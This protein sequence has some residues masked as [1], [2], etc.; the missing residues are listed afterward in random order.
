MSYKI[1]HSQVAYYSIEE[2]IYVRANNVNSRNSN[3]IRLPIFNSE[4]TRNSIFSE[5]IKLFDSTPNKPKM[6]EN[7][8]PFKIVCKEC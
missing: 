7:I 4:I 3:D 5:G 2:V 6:T 8:N 1:K